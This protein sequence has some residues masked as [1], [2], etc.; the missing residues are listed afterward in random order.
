MS[1]R[2]RFS[3]GSKILYA[4]LVVL[5]LLMFWPASR[6]VLQ[7]GLMKIGLFK[8]KVENAQP[9]DATDTS[10]PM[11]THE[12]VTL[13]DVDGK[14]IHTADLKGKVV[15]IN[16]W[17]TW[18]GPC[19]AEMPSIQ[20]LIERIGEQDDIA[21]LLV[22]VDGDMDVAK[23]FLKKQKLDL[24]IFVPQSDIPSTWMSGA[25]PATVVLDK[26]GQRVFSHKGMADY[27]DP[28][29]VDYLKKLAS[30]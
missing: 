27:S 25:I 29:F 26:E 19:V 13:A 4:I 12:G 18:C 2:P 7:R 23:Q 30:E 20:T 10:G 14:S 15:F 3:L 6:A 22:D 21:F 5:I 8:P 11:A 9:S 24:P 28:E 16:F 1:N 17:A